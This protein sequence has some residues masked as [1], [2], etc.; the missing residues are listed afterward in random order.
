VNDRREEGSDEVWA[1][2][3]ACGREW[4]CVKLPMRLEAAVR[5]LKAH[6]KS[7]PYCGAKRDSVKWG[8]RL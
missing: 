6:G 8:K 4:L 5:I 2:C 1:H 7:C 3:A